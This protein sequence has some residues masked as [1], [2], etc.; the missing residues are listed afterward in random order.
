MPREF[1]RCRRLCL[2]VERQGRAPVWVAQ[3][4]LAVTRDGDRMYQSAR[5]NRVLDGVGCGCRRYRSRN[6]CNNDRVINAMWG[7]A[8]QSAPLAFSRSRGLELCDR[9]P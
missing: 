2:E 6:L 9:P 4:E 1:E 5:G 7:T 8:S 3:F